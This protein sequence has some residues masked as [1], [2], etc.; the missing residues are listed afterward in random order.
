[1]LAVVTL[2][3]TRLAC[4]RTVKFAILEVTTFS[5]VILAVAMFPV[6]TLALTRLAC[7]RTIRVDTL[8]VVMLAV[9]TNRLL[10][11]MTSMFAVPRTYRLEPMG[12]FVRVP[13]LTPFWYATLPLTVVH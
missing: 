1:M 13:M 6:V 2:A 4:V 9:A 3:L 11:L 5:V 12:G 10:V 8:S 7:V